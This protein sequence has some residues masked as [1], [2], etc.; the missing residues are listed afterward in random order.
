MVYLKNWNLIL[1]KTFTKAFKAWLSTQPFVKNSNVLFPSLN[2]Y[3][4]WN[5]ASFCVKISRVFFLFSRWCGV[6]GRMKSTSTKVYLWKLPYF[7]QK[8]AIVVETIIPGV[9]FIEPSSS[10]QPPRQPRLLIINL[11]LV[12]PGSPEVRVKRSLNSW[13]S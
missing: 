4:R 5:Q 11:T 3:L 2:Q 12:W 13:N 9:R 8:K 10:I 6:R 1:E 7:I